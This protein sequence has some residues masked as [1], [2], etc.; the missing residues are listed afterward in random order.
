[1]PRKGECMDLTGQKF[2]RWLV[3][4]LAEPTFNK[5]GCV[6]QRWKCRC[7]CGNER[8]VLQA[9]LRSGKSKSCGCLNKEMVGN[10]HRTHGLTNK[11]NG[12]YSIWSGMKRRCYYK[13]SPDYPDYGGRGITVCHE[14]KE[15]FQAFYD[16]SMANGYKKGLSIER[17]DVNGDYCPENCCWISLIDQAKNKRN[18]MT[19][20]ERY[21]ICPIC[22]KKYEINSRKGKN[23]CSQTCGVKLRDMKHPREK[24]KTSVC[25]I[26]GK[27]FRKRKYH[28]KDRI[29]CSRECMGL[30]KSPIL[31]Y[32]GEKHRVIEWAEIT[33]IKA[34]AIL[35]RMKYGW[36][37]ER[38]LTT[39]VREYGNGGNKD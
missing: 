7:D 22:G 39:P 21:K 30:G 31:E 37:V 32:N 13:K 12:L 8:V 38:I 1:M 33:G 24:F 16:W 20:E 11:S 5:K 19:D 28:G 34:S 29:Y 23:T 14:W 25:V 15:D 10:L 4:E 36:D 35:N 6:E 26:C 27:E 2:D 17:K 9:S 3:I 18:T